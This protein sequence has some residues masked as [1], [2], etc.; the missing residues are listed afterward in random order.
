ME[1]PAV[2]RGEAGGWAASTGNGIP[3]L[4]IIDTATG[5]VVSSSFEGSEYVGCE[6][7]LGVLATIVAQGHP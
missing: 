2:L 1:F 5:K 3:N 7:P 4:M 6:K